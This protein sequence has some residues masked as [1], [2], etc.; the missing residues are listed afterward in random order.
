MAERPGVGVGAEVP[1]HQRAVD[2][3]VRQHRLGARVK[4]VDVDRAAVLLQVQTPGRKD[5][6]DGRDVFLRYK[7]FTCGCV[8]VTW[9]GRAGLWGIWVV[10]LLR[11]PA[12]GWIRCQRPRLSNVSPDRRSASSRDRRYENKSTPT[13]GSTAHTQRFPLTVC[14]SVLK[15]FQTSVTD[16]YN[17]KTLTGSI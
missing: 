8:C 13:C 6:E 7:G 17:S 16:L 4:M 11:L 10:Y 5:N 2:G 3:G 14:V 15:C 12:A 9:S 1:A